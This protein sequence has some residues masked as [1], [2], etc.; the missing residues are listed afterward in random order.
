M[1]PIT[2]GQLPAELVNLLAL[3]SSFLTALSLHYAHNGVSSPADLRDI[4]TSATGD[5]DRSRT[6]TFD[7][8]LASSITGHQ[9]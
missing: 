2:P 3:H 8:S 9:G 6:M 1:A 5:S 7:C 4:T